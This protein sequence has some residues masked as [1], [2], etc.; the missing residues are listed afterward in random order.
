MTLP[1]FTGTGYLAGE[2]PDG[3]TTV[4]GVP[5]AATVQVLWRDPD[6]DEEHLVASTTSTSAGTWQITDLNHELQYVVRG[7]KAG[8]NDVSVVGATPTRMDVVTAT[9]AFAANED[10]NG[11]DGTV[12]IEGGLPPYSVSIVSGAL[13]A[14]LSAHIA[15]HDLTIAGTSTAAGTYSATLRV[16]A[17]NAVW[18]DV[19][20]E[21][22][23]I[24][25]AGVTV[26][27]LHGDEATGSTT[28]V[29][30]SPVPKTVTCS[31]GPMAAAFASAYGG[32]AINIPGTGVV[33]VADHTDFDFAGKNWCVE[34]DFFLA[35]SPSG[36]QMLFNKAEGTNTP[37]PVQIYM[38]AS[39]EVIARAYGAG[40]VE[41]WTMS[42]G[43]LLPIGERSTIAVSR[44]GSTFRAFV[45][46]VLKRTVT[47]SG[48]PENPAQ[49]ISIGGYSTGS[50]SANGHI[51]EVRVTMGYALRTA[52]YT[53]PTAAYP[54]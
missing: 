23:V 1:T 42:T 18:A 2:S 44:E 38:T 41:H 30:S 5:V 50:Y 36:S 11:V 27:L 48:T 40:V 9:G 53:R 34:L 15:G 22:L 37:Y 16:T 51:E 35:S 32:S 21:D 43:T 47:F 25:D 52:S 17:S 46:G 13:P 31:G 28:L 7:I 49:P 24:A 6:T 26:L 12:L 3:L 45:N 10:G 20:V 14:G 8:W 19:D 4:V 39:R 54:G 29:D 33:L